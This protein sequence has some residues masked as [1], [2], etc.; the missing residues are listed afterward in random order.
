[1]F[2]IHRD[3]ISKE[4]AA[5]C[6][7]AMPSSPG[8]KYK[9]LNDAALYLG[10]LMQHDEAASDKTEYTALSGQDFLWVICSAHGGPDAA[11]ADIARYTD[12]GS[13][14]VDE[15]ARFR[16]HVEVAKL[17]GKHYAG[18]QQATLRLD[19]DWHIW[20][21]KL[22]KNGDWDNQ[23]SPDGKTVTMRY[24]SGGQY[25]K[26]HVFPQRTP[27]KGIII[28]GHK[29]DPQTGQ[30]YYEFV[31]I[32]TELEGNYAHASCERIAETLYIDGNGGF[33]VHN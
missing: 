22:Y 29:L 14:R 6:G 10:G 20:F 8:D 16:T 12:K 13:I 19:D 28:F 11:S 17:F 27:G 9:L 25:G 30:K 1:M 31:G 24:V 2:A 21:P 7:V 32:F 5:T 15:T 4:L 3:W 33:S 26:G 23:I 18:H